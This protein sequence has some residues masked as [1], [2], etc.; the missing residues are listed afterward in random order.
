M[1]KMAIF[2]TV[3]SPLDL[4]KYNVQE[5]GLAQGLLKLGISVDIYSRFT[6]IK[7]E[8]V[9]EKVKNNYIKL[10][11]ITGFTLKGRII[12]FSLKQRILDNKYDIVQTHEYSQIMTP[13]IL[14]WAREKNATTVLY[15]GAY[16]RYSGYKA[17]I[18]KIYN[19][20][21]INSINKNCDYYFAKTGAAQQYLM[22]NNLNK[23]NHI[24]PVGLYFNK[25]F[26]SYKNIERIKKFR[27]KFDYLLLYIGKIEKRR[28][29]SF[30]LDVLTA[31]R[32]KN[33][34]LLIV[35]QGPD[36]NNLANEIVKLKLNH[37]VLIIKGIPNNQLKQIY[38]LAD[39]FLLPSLYEPY[40]MVILESLYFGLPVIA[41]KT[42]GPLDIIKDKKLGVCLELNPQLWANHIKFFLEMKNHENYRKNYIISNYDWDKIAKRYLNV[43]FEG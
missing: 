24:L 19:K 40:G 32:A 35:G 37:Q 11:P 18:Q 20:I 23:N 42:A 2:R 14:K 39:L 17:L 41:S 21:F 8:N 25:K 26:H 16:E 43:I 7:N 6:D 31:L 38:E 12:D 9:I 30:I 10:I 13:L 1:G 36:I 27:S 5:I 28:N 15:Q 33:L 29:I 22:N 4:S 3:S 34:G